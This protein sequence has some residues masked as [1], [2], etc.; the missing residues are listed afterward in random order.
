M[1]W[2]RVE[3]H[4][5]QKTP[6]CRE[7]V[8][9]QVD[10]CQRAEAFRVRMDPSI[11]RQQALTS[12]RTGVTPGEPIA[13]AWNPTLILQEQQGRSAALPSSLTDS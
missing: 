2:F 11:H 7:C 1:G 12:L 13:A 6:S 4:L 5:G 8:A 3:T 10:F 9:R